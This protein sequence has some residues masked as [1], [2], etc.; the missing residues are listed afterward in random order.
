MAAV[1]QLASTRLAVADTHL[2]LVVRMV[3]LLVLQCLRVQL[4]L[5]CR[6]HQYQ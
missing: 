1:V 2:S 5:A 6:L 4:L 3:L